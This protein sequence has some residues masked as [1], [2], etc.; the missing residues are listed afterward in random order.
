M[1][2]VWKVI[3][4]LIPILLLFGLIRFYFHG[5]QGDLIPDYAT[6]E[7]WFQ[8]FPDIGA[9]WRAAVSYFNAGSD[10]TCPVNSSDFW[11]IFGAMWCETTKSLDFNNWFKGVSGVLTLIITTPMKVLGWFFSIFTL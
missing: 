4:F 9:E 5:M 6:F 10:K 8:S 7:G 11:D 3:V 1:R 2:V